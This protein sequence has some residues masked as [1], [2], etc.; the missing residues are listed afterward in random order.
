M[1]LQ[2]FS[3]MTEYLPK[4]QRS[5]RMTILKLLARRKPGLFFV[6]SHRTSV[7]LCLSIY[8]RKKC[9]QSLASLT[10]YQQLLDHLPT[11]RIY[12]RLRCPM[13]MDFQQ[14]YHCHRVGSYSW[15]SK[16]YTVLGDCAHIL[17]STRL[18]YSIILP[19]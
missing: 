17:R 10:S 16:E 13:I 11:P 19:D 5:K 4:G 8:T 9:Y 7:D 2:Y 3:F 1:D 15:M 18:L 12:F 6:P 14:S